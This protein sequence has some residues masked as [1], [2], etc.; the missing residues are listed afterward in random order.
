M[1]DKWIYEYTSRDE[2]GQG[3]T[4]LDVRSWKTEE[5]TD[6]A[7]T[8]PEGTLVG[9]RV[10]VLE[11]SPKGDRVDP[12]P[13]Y[14]IQGES[15]YPDVDWDPS[16][17]QLKPDFKSGLRTYLSP[18]FCFPL[19]L[20]KTWGAPHGLPDWAVAR[21]EEAKDWQVVGMNIRDKREMFHIASISSYPGGGVT[22]DIWFE[23]DVGILLEKEVHHGT[24]GEHKKR[25]LSFEPASKH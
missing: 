8:I 10:R 18:N 22:V 17:H 5:T 6:G 21:P 9:R 7:W 14:L 19:I 25:L 13:A 1:N 20:H 12:N 23:K 3:R 24:I 2:N 15:L 11:G 16:T 4:H